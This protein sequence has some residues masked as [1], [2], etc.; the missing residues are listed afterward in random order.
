MQRAVLWLLRFC[1]GGAEV[2]E[3]A[4][5]HGVPLDIIS[6]LY[7]ISAVSRLVCKGET[8]DTDLTIDIN[9]DVYPVRVGEKLSVAIASTLRLDGAPTEFA[10]DQSG[11]VR[12]GVWCMGP[13]GWANGGGSP[14]SLAIRYVSCSRGGIPPGVAVGPV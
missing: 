6:S 12:V 9:A 7:F 10:W 13:V 4:S 11:Q 8:Y 2:V 14:L 3:G 1:S 5:V